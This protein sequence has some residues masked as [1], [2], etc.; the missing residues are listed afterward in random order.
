MRAVIG[1]KLVVA[2]RHVGEPAQQ[3]L[4][5][6]VEG[7]NGEPPYL[8]R[9]EWDGHEGLFFPGPDVSVEHYPAVPGA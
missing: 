1:D 2:G 8:V 5:L 6:A 3:A 4:V 7:E 9:W